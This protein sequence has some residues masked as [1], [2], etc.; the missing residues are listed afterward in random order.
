MK[1]ML[2]LLLITEVAFSKP[3]VKVRDIKIDKTPKSLFLIERKV[4]EGEFGEPNIYPYERQLRV[5]SY[6]TRLENP[7]DSK[8]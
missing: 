5:I 1:A 7:L 6:D 4:D 2:V 8:R 3:P